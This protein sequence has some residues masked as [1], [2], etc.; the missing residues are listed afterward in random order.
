MTIQTLFPGFKSFNYA[1]LTIPRLYFILDV[2]IE[3]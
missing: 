1:L 2:E 3:G